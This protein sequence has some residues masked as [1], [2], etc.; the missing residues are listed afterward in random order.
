[1]IVS[2]PDVVD[3]VTH[4]LS[5]ERFGELKLPI[6]ASLEFNRFVSLF[7]SHLGKLKA[8]N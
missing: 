6:F 5:E 1:M 4:T 2:H 3:V 7:F 8:V